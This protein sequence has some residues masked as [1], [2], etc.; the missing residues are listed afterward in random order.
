MNNYLQLSSSDAADAQHQ[1]QISK[2]KNQLSDK[3]KQI[4]SAMS[5]F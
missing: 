2:L 5:N 4:M 3:K 1:L